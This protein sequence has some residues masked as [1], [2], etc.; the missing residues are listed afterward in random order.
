[1]GSGSTNKPPLSE[2]PGPLGG[3][4]SR[5]EQIES[6][7]LFRNMISEIK[8]SIP[9]IPVGG[10]LSQYADNWWTLI[11]NEWCQNL[12]EEGLKIEFMAGRPGRAPIEEFKLS[13][14]D[15]QLIDEENE[16]L[17]RKNV[18]EEVEN[19]PP[20]A[21]YSPEFVIPKK[22]GGRRPVWDGRHINAHVIKRR[23][24][25][26]SLL[27]VRHLVRRDDYMVVLD[28]K[29]AYHHI[30]ISKRY[31]NCFRF[32]WRGRKYRWKAMPFGLHSSPQIWTKLMQPVV[33]ILRSIG[34][35]CIIYLDDFLIL[36]FSLG[37]ARADTITVLRV[38]CFLG[39]TVNWEKSK[40]DPC[41]NQ[42]YLGLT[43][44]SHNMKFRVPQA[45]VRDIKKELRMVQS[46]AEKNN[47][48]LRR[49]SRLIGKLMAIELA[50]LPTRLRTWQL[51]HCRNRQ[52]RTAWDELIQ[53][54]DSA[55][56]EIQWWIENLS[57]WNGRA[58]MLGP[59]TQRIQSDAS[60]KG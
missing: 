32:F 34:I 10:K 44:D 15:Q 35:R 16:V 20:D 52:L 23:F 5:C 50:V 45:K 11:G 18:I 8:E 4:A 28:L 49:F 13:E 14:K 55:K 24:K 33:K 43:I 19:D 2:D 6:E 59:P 9:Q 53:L 42:Q 17:L 3:I 47:L 21:I 26:E 60:S 38:L 54:D 37:Q 25:M 29:D 41:R 30:K 57:N 48:T 58:I 27:T 46:L 7:E 51:L 1:L 12:I 22:N 56:E 40:L 31:V 39:L 36:A